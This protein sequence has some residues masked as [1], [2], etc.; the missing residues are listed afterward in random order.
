[1]F[2]RMKVRS[3]PKKRAYKSPARERQADDTRR[4]IVA[5]S[6]ELL[7]AEG[8]DGM[9]IEAIAQKAEVSA[10]SIYANYKS[11]AG[12][13]AELMDQS[14]Y[15]PA[16]QDTVREAHGTPDPEA[17]LRVAARIAR[18]VH[19]AQGAA[20]DLLR[21]AGVVAPELAKLEQQREALRYKRQE[22]LITYLRDAGRL[23]RELQDGP[24]R[25]VLWMLTGRDIYRSLVRERRWSPEQYERWLAD[26]LVQS[27][28][29]TGTRRPKSART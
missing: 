15:G 10:P 16:Y 4:R 2:I 22:G 5:A 21:G 6:R 17:R 19:E 12:I 29:T 7:M 20:F 25:D 26:A 8:Y 1:M 18:S 11:K 9:T 28:M 14:S 3:R 27:L 23:R 13:L 24:A